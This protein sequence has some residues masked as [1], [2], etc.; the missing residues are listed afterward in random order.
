LLEKTSKLS[1][2]QQELIAGHWEWAL[3]VVQKQEEEKKKKERLLSGKA[4]E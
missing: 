4:G 2:D 1:Q 3:K